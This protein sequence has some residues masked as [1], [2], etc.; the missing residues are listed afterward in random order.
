MMTIAEK[1]KTEALA[2]PVVTAQRIVVRDLTLSCSI[3]VS[4]AEDSLSFGEDDCLI[5]HRLGVEPVERQ[6]QGV[7]I[8]VAC[9][10]VVFRLDC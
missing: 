5:R 8:N 7:S 10:G 2:K 3:G 4:P 1:G 6:R 9:K